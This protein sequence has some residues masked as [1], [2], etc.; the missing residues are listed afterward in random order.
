MNYT[1][2]QLEEAYTALLSTLKK[3]EK[4][5]TSNFGKSQKT[6]L[7]TRVK[8]LRLALDLIEREIGEIGTENQCKEKMSKNAYTTRNVR[9]NNKHSKV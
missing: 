6:L 5:N 1:K 2:E 3:C 8:A 7:K 9:L 4:I